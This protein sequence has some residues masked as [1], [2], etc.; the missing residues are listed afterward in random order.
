M[1]TLILAA[2]RCSLMFL[3]PSVTYA[4]S[5]QW[6]L[7]PI[8]SDWNTPVNWT[9]D[10]VPNGPADIATFGLSNNTF[11]SI[12]EDV[13]VNSIIFTP[14]ATNPYTIMVGGFNQTSRPALTLS[15]AGIINNSGIPQTFVVGAF[16]VGGEMRFTN[17]ASAG[18]ARI[19]LTTATIN[20]FNRSTA[21]SASIF[22]EEEAS[23]NFFNASTAGSALIDFLGGGNF[24]TFHDSST[25]GSATVLVGFDSELRFLGHSSAGNAT[26][27]GSP[28]SGFIAFFGSATAGRANIQGNFSTIVFGELSK[29]GTAAI[30]LFDFSNLDISGHDASGVTI[31][32]LEGNETSNVFLGG[33]NLTVGS[34]D[35]STTYSG[36]IDGAG[37]SFTKIGTGTLDLTGANTYTGDTNVNRGVL[38]VDGSITSNTFINHRGTLAGTGTINGNVVNTDFGTV[39]PGGALGAPGVLTVTGNYTQTQFATLM[40]QIAGVSAGEFSV[41]N[42][43]GNANLN[44]FLDPVLLNGFV[45]TLGDSFV[46]LNYASLTGEFSHIKHRIFNDGMLQWSVIYEANHAILTVEQH[47]PD[48]GSTFLL[49]SLGLLGLVT[50]RRQLTRKPK[51]LL[52]LV[53]AAVVFLAHPAKANLIT[54]GGFE[55]G[56]FTGWTQSGNTGHTGVDSTF[57]HIPPHSGAHHAYFGPVGDHGF[58]TQILAT[59]PGRS[60]TINFWLANYKAHRISSLSIGVIRLF[61]V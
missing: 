15:G 50:Y 61:S 35:L 7:D 59:T 49:L 41:L 5:A 1:K 37:G 28:D 33:N 60:Y 36:V 42:V 13:E 12:Q 43:L 16:E 2:I 53:A 18:N 19:Y 23:V 30:G 58:I 4:I 48:H 14:A 10:G 8:S 9:P 57:F 51:I 55:T 24:V 46:F 6:D 17:S 11:V 47:V 25:A 32:S 21:S 22:S 54:N 39:R 34:N 26:I 31:G 45:P 40:I 44:G 3:V 38:Q 20:F 27:M 29:G 52:A 56:D